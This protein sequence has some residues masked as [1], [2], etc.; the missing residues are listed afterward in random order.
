MTCTGGARRTCSATNG[1]ARATTARAG[2]RDDAH[3]ALNRSNE[4]ARVL[5]VSNFALPRSAVQVD[6][7]KIMICW[8]PRPEDSLWFRKDDA[9]D[10]WD[11][12]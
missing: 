11:G 6:S 1:P 12:E 3:Q 8:G 2:A 9:V 5:M 7:G 10:I 4:P